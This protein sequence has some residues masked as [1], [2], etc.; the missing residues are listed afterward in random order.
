MIWYWRQDEI[1]SIILHS[2][3]QGIYK[4]E[5]LDSLVCQEDFIS[6]KTCQIECYSAERKWLKALFFKF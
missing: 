5:Q 1:N 3:L 2:H 6:Q 4:K